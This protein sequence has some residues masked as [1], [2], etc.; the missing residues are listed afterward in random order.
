MRPYR[1]I[2]CQRHTEL[3][4]EFCEGAVVLVTRFEGGGIVEV[5]LL[6]SRSF[7]KGGH[8]AIFSA[9]DSTQALWALKAIPAALTSEEKQV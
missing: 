8:G 5:K 9:I 1:A 4:E 6:S 7:D 2:C 3:S